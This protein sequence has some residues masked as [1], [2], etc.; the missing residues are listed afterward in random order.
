MRKWLISAVTALVMATG[1]GVAQADDVIKIGLQSALTG[2]GAAWGQPFR[3]TTEMYVDE[4]NAAGGLE[5]GGKK[6]MIELFVDDH[7]ADVKLAKSGLERFV[8]QEGIKLLMIHFDQGP[9]AWKGLP[10][11]VRKGLLH[12]SPV[13]RPDVFEPIAS[14]HKWCQTFLFRVAP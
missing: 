9:D 2:W 10:E 13:W 3:A 5:V 12:V 8:Y 11:D 14:T 4:V 1:A 7:Q 6:Y